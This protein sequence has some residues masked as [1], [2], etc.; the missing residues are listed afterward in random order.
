MICF[1]IWF[2][3]FELNKFLLLLLLYYTARASYPAEAKA[4]PPVTRPRPWP[5]VSKSIP[6][7]TI[8]VSRSSFKSLALL[9]NSHCKRLNDNLFCCLHHWSSAALDCLPSATELFQSPLLVSGT[10]CLK[11]SS[12]HSP[13][14]LTYLLTVLRGCLPVWSDRDPSVPASHLIS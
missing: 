10:V 9:E 4:W 11:T 2:V 5:W 12:P 13:C 8:L 14:L 7:P 3:D 1:C 6:K